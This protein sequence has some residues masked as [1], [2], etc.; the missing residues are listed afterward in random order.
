[1]ISRRDSFVRTAL[2][3]ALLFSL[4]LSSAEALVGELRDGEVHH[5]DVSTAVS[6][7][8]MAGGRGDHGHE[9]ASQPGQHEHGEKHQHGTSVDHCTHLHAVGL[10]ATISFGFEI[11]LGSFELPFITGYD[12]N[13]VAALAE[14]PRA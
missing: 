7:R 8:D 6:H 14:P 4:G 3:V 1:M 12:E 11:R 2:A 10:A 5:E 9:D 13:Y